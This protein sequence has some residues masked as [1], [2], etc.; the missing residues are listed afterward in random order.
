[1]SALHP[2][3]R[4][5]LFRLTQEEYESLKQAC[6]DQ[7]G[8]NLSEFTRSALFSAVRG[9]FGDATGARQYREIESRLAELQRLVEKLV[10]TQDERRQIAVSGS[11]GQQ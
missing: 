9:G 6:L 3:S 8:R 1:M 11:G 10:D 2:R 4:V 7:G 5:V